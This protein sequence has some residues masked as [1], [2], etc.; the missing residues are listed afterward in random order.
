MRICAPVAASRADSAMM[1]A[2]VD[3]PSLPSATSVAPSRPT[4]AAEV[5]M[6][7]MNCARLVAAVSADKFVVSPSCTIVFVKLATSSRAIPS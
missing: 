5:P 7:F 3:A 4:E 6:M 1:S 2:S